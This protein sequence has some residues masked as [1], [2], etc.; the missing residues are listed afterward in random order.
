MRTQQTMTLTMLQ[1]VLVFSVSWVVRMLQVTTHWSCLREQTCCW[2][3]TRALLLHWLLSSQTPRWGLWKDY[4]MLIAEALH[5][6]NQP[7][8]MLS[9]DYAQSHSCTSTVQFI[10]WMYCATRSFEPTAVH[11]NQRC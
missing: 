11:C 6:M 8:F 4:H 1:Q 5:N 9:I 2:K 3:R 10:L 7:A